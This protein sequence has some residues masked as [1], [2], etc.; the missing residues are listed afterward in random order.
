MYYFTATGI[1]IV[2]FFE[3]IHQYH[4]T[5]IWWAPIRRQADQQRAADW[6]WSVHARREWLDR[7]QTHFDKSIFSLRELFF[8]LVL[9]FFLIPSYFVAFI[10]FW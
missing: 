7:H 9:F 3:R 8:S 4:G 10:Q 6:A 1:T 5:K 2:R